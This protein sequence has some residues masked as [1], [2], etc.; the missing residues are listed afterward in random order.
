MKIRLVLLLLI[1]VITGVCAEKKVQYSLVCGDSSI[2]C[3]WTI[4]PGFSYFQRGEEKQTIVYNTD[5]S[6]S[7]FTYIDTLLDTDYT[8]KREGNSIKVSGKIEGKAINKVLSINRLPW[9]QSMHDFSRFA[10]DESQKSL[11]CWAVRPTDVKMA[12]M[13]AVKVKKGSDEQVQVIKVFPQGLG[14]LF[15]QAHYTY[16]KKDCQFLQY[17]SVNGGP[18]TPE[19]V[20]LPVD[21]NMGLGLKSGQKTI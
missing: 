13:K 16:R 12:K 5:S 8:M 15:W 9:Y 2:I 18:G 20:I 6:V 19:T 14:A 1:V 17:R 10:C 11:H 4:A 7:S 21:K 3:N